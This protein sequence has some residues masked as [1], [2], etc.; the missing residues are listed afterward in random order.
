MSKM[1]KTLSVK[2]LVQCANAML[3]N[4]VNSPSYRAGVQSMVEEILHTSG[5]YKGF[6]YLKQEEVPPQKWPG[7][8]TQADGTMLPPSERFKFTDRTRVAYCEPQ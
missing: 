8:H 1:R 4:S 2:Q 6:R 5:N 3:K 7:I